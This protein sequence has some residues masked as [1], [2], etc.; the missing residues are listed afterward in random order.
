[1][2][3]QLLKISLPDSTPNSFQLGLFLLG[4][5]AGNVRVLGLGLHVH[6]AGEQVLVP[7]LQME[8]EVRA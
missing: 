6:E 2:E 8:T 1:M 7:G 3:P 4:E 5:G